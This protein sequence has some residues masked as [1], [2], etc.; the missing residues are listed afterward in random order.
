[1][2]I[3]AKAIVMSN[4]RNIQRQQS[5]SLPMNRI[6]FGHRNSPSSSCCSIGTSVHPVRYGTLVLSMIP[7][8]S[9]RTLSTILTAIATIVRYSEIS[10][11]D[12]LSREGGLVS[13]HHHPMQKHYEELP[14]LTLKRGVDYQIHQFHQNIWVALWIG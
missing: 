5:G 10:I 6:P 9:P 2:P 13:S 3:S 8:N 4:P 11:T 14:E 7:K 1:M 12:H